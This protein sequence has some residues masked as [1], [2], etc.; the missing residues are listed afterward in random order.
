MRHTMARWQ[1][2]N[3][4]KQVQPVR[5]ATMSPCLLVA[6]SLCLL[7]GCT[8]QQPADPAI[9]AAARGRED[10]TEVTATTDGTAVLVTNPT[11]IGS[12]RIGRRGEHW[13]PLLAVRLVY[14]PDK[15]FQALHTLT[16]RAGGETAIEGRTG[17]LGT[18]D[19]LFFSGGT[20]G[21]HGSYRI[22]IQRRA[23]Y[24]QITLPPELLRHAGDTIELSW[25]DQM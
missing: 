16:I 4:R 6:M 3:A 9:S 25:V 24:L 20:G 21:Y 1:D 2:D 19:V 5:L 15:E 13:P 10:K 23:R 17:G 22:D 8:N 12:V 11:G 7:A 18:R 14:S